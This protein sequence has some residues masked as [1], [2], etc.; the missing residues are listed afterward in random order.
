MRE[1]PVYSQSQK[2]APLH[3]GE[4]VI[5]HGQ[6]RGWSSASLRHYLR[7]LVPSTLYYGFKDLGVGDGMGVEVTMT[8]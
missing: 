1:L 5:L 3:T 4:S 7:W 8:T 6:W 2:L